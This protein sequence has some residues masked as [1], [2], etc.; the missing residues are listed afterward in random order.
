MKAAWRFEELGSKLFPL[1]FDQSTSTPAN[2]MAEELWNFCC[3]TR[4]LKQED[5]KDLHR[6]LENQE[7]LGKWCLVARDWLLFSVGAVSHQYGKN[8]SPQHGELARESP[9]WMGRWCL[10]EHEVSSRHRNSGSWG[11]VPPSPF[12]SPFFHPILPLQGQRAAQQKH[13]LPQIQLVMEEKEPP[14]GHQ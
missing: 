10:C 14:S 9:A 3:V 1:V 4:R 2:K 11:T 12:S 13:A 6:N 7:M 5:N 8:S